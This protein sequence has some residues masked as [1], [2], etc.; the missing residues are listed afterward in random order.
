[1]SAVNACFR[2]GYGVCA[3]FVPNA[4]PIR[5]ESSLKGPSSIPQRVSAIGG[6]MVETTVCAL[7]LMR[8][9]LEGGEQSQNLIFA[10]IGLR[11]GWK[12]AKLLL[13]I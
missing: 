11:T 5:L 8:N 12:S 13:R 1:M 6:V 4:C 9:S 3:N 10:L 2:F 7:D